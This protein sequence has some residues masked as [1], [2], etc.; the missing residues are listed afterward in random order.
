MRSHQFWSIEHNY[1]IHWVTFIRGIGSYQP[2]YL[3]K[4]SDLHHWSL[5]IGIITYNL[6]LYLP[7]LLPHKCI[8]YTHILPYH[9]AYVFAIHNISHS[10]I[11]NIY[12]VWWEDAHLTFHDTTSMVSLL[13]FSFLLAIAFCMYIC[14][15]WLGK[16]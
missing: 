1:P 5:S 3:I 4:S 2:Y 6:W 16:V 8:S 7:F 11:T 10:F 9:I 15:C 13:R 14:P 12:S